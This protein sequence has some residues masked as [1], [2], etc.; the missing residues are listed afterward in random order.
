MHTHATSPALEVAAC[1][2]SGSKNLDSANLESSG[3]SSAARVTAASSCMRA[4][5]FST[6]VKLASGLRSKTNIR[7]MVRLEHTSYTKGGIIGPC[8]KPDVAADYEAEFLAVEL[9][10]EFVED[11]G[12]RSALL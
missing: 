6:V 10:F 2:L 3:R 4:I 7:V 8:K 11:P 1:Q 5:R 12:L 9:L